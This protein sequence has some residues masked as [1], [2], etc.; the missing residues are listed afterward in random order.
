MGPVAPA[1]RLSKRREQMNL[2]ILVKAVDLRRAKAAWA[3]APRALQPHA[4]PRAVPPARP[5]PLLRAIS[6]A[7]LALALGGVLLWSSPAEAQNPFRIL[8]SNSGHSAELNDSFALDADFPRHAQRFTTGSDAPGYTLETILIGFYR[9][10][11]RSAPG[12]ELTVTL[13]EESNGNPG[14]ALCTLIDPSN[15]GGFGMHTFSAPNTGMDQCPVL[16][17]NT[18]YFAVIERANLDTSTIELSITSTYGGDS[19]S[20]EGWLIGNGAHHY[21][22]ANTPPWTHSSDSPNLFFRVHGVGIPHP[23]RVTGFDL[24][25]DNDNPKGI[26]GNGKTIW[27][28]QSGTGPKLFAYNR[29]DGSRDSSQD[30]NTLSAAGNGAPTGLCSDGT[31]MFVVDMGDNK[32]Y[33]YT[34]STGARDSAKD[35]TLASGNTMAEGVWC[36]DDT[37][38]VV[39]DDVTGSNEIFA[40]NRVDGTQNTDV[41]FPD[42]DPEVMGSPLNAD[43]RG[44]WSNGK[45]MF[46]VDDEDAAVYAWN[47]SDQTRGMD[48]EDKEIALDSDN[49]DPEG[50][51]FDGRVLWV[52]DDADDRVYVYD[53]PGA[54]PDNARADG[55]PGV[56]TSSSKDA[57]AATLTVGRH[58]TGHGYISGTT[59]VTGSL[60]SQATF[61]LGGVTYT[62]VSLYTGAGALVIGLDKY[63]TREFTLSVAGESYVSAGRRVD[64]FASS[65]EYIWRD[66]G[67]SWSASNTISVSLSFDSA[68]KEGGEL[69]ADVSGIK[70]STDGVANAFFHYQWVRVDGTDETELDGE[71]GPAYTPTDA[72]GGKHLKVRVVFDDDAGNQEYPRTSPQVGPVGMN[73]PASGAPAITGTPRA[74][75]MLTVDLSAIMDP[76]GTDDAEF[77]YQWIRIDGGSEADIP[78]ATQATYRP[79]DEDA[80]KQ[81]KVKVSF[82]DDEGFPEGPLASEPTATIVAA[83]VLVKNTGQDPAV[84]TYALSTTTSKRAH[85]FTTGPD[86]V[87]YELHSVGFR[88]ANIASTSNAGTELTATLH[89]TS[90]N[91]PGTELCTLDDPASFSASGV[92]TFTAPTS[93]NNRCPKLTHSTTYFVVLTRA[94]NNTSTITLSVTN[95]NA[96]DAGSSDGW[97][98]SNNR[99]QYSGTSWAQSVSQS[100]MIEV[101]GDTAAAPIVS[102]HRTWVDNRQ[103]VASTNYENTGAFTIAQGFRTGDTFG[104]FEVHEIHVDFDRGQPATGKIQVRIVESTAPDDFWEYATP[105]RLLEGGQ[106][107]APNRDHRRRPHLPQGIRKQRP[108]GQHQLLPGHRVNQR[109]LSRRG[110]RPHDQIRRRRLQRRLDRRQ[111]L[112]LQ[113]QAAQRNLDQAGP[114]GA[115]PHLGKLQG[116]HRHGR[117][118][119]RL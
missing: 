37:V 14:T 100:Y 30:F 83:D 103:G 41:G 58:I 12:G 115:F 60:S 110:H 107:Q 112:T 86:T 46:V 113:G 76:E 20:L 32:V 65:E 57:W 8:V 28:S 16:R 35:I 39:E 53:L 101:K 75:G 98:I 84:P 109:R 95:S 62:V 23:R 51:W 63:P 102:G 25:S 111:L 1:T 17:A 70:D 21:V 90:G 54:Q 7:L 50:L 44:I 27:V 15:F 9:I 68:P 24:H 42:L 114:R 72:D 87:G 29:S 52:V 40:Y 10:A 13:N 2:S 77:T 67:L 97:T 26:W 93:G 89:Q 6:L 4:G 104:I 5:A 36:D 55:V 117:R 47:V 116:R 61:T 45:T 11:D 18:T 108:E 73:G 91:D 22:S 19:N 99:S 119:L 71:T 49:A 79:T 56:R 80:D 78:N 92:N 118:L 66:A 64:L 74:G 96:E 88:F 31:T 85:A 43:P 105:F 81:I 33:A 106:L 3:W 34:L 94:N 48:E 69:R 82:T 59:P 38:W